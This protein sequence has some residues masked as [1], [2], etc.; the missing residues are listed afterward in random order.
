VRQG[1]AGCAAGATVRAASARRQP[2]VG[3]RLAPSALP[4][5]LLVRPASALRVAAPS[6]D[7]RRPG[8]NGAAGA[9][10]LPSYLKLSFTLAR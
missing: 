2:A 6:L 7:A 9:Y 8:R 3:Q 10:S 4:P 1:V 5:L